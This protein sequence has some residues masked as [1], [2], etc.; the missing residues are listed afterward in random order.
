MTARAVCAESHILAFTTGYGEWGHD[1]VA[2][3]EGGIQLRSS[4]SGSTEMEACAEC[5]DF[6]DNF[7]SADMACATQ[8][9]EYR[10]G[11]RI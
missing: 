9:V 8:K 3:L 2:Y 1:L 7:M 6:A 4:S 5:H 10:P 11:D